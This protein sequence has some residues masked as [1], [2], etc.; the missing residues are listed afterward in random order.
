MTIKNEAFV[1]GR[2]D[3]EKKARGLSDY[4]EAGDIRKDV[5]M[6]KEDV[7]ALTRH[8]KDEGIDQIRKAQKVAQ[9]KWARVQDIGRA[10]LERTREMV[11]ENPVQGL[12]VAFFA[13]I[14]LSALMGRRH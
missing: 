5:D 11:K 13:G 2:N 9:K 6:L 14:V 1:N 3:I 10:E 12:A 4:S 7:V 8:V